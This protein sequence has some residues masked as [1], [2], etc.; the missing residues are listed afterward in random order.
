M[1]P[2]HHQRTCS[3][4][5]LPPARQEA[6]AGR[7]YRKIACLL[8]SGEL[9]FQIEKR[10]TCTVFARVSVPLLKASTDIC[11][12]DM[13]AFTGRACVVDYGIFYFV[14]QLL[15]DTW[16]PLCSVGKLSAQ[17]LLTS[18]HVRVTPTFA[19][20]MQTPTHLRIVFRDTYCLDVHLRANRCVSVRDGAFSQFDLS[21][22]LESLTPTPGLRV[23]T[24]IS[25]ASAPY[26]TTTSIC[27]A[28]IPFL[29]NYKISP[30]KRY[31]Y[32][33]L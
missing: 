9:R 1:R 10:C 18:G 23:S 25:L 26:T 32:Q 2:T 8:C 24:V 16:S 27:A 13:P 19:V 14:F 3:A 31:I 28:D 7:H 15:V 21:K 20:V 11:A 22:A 12:L 33:E 6:P 29:K 30:S 17:V 4:R 5:K